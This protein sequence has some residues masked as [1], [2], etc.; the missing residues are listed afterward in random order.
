VAV[1]LKE[2]AVRV[3]ATVRGDDSVLIEGIATLRNAG[4]RDLS[5]FAN[6]RYRRD[7]RETRAGAVLLAPEDL[8]DCPVP[9]LVAANTRLA[10]A[11]IAELLH[12]LPAVEAGVHPDASVSP[13]AELGAGVVV[14]AGSVVEAGARLGAG[15]QVGPGC[16]V[17]RDVR[18]GGGSRL[19]ASVTLCHG[20]SIGCRVLIHP[21][22]VIGADGFG[23]ALEEGVWHKVPQIGSVQI[24]D[25]VEIG[26]NTTVDRGAIEDTVIEEGVKLD[27]Q[28]QVAHNVHIGAHT[29][30][31]GC[32]GIAGSTRIGRRCQIAGA[33]EISGHLE[34]VDDV[35]VTVGSLVT[36]DIREPGVYSSGSPLM[37]NG[38][39]R[40]SMARIKQIDELAKRI[41]A[42]E[43][44][45]AELGE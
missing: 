13:E 42:L 12:P 20:V 41:K 5:F 40:R 1:T 28:I 9:A 15:V 22:A 34:I 29:A 24:G 17:G 35:V 26:A 30:I 14:G 19:V 39:W 33:A 4:P 6:R 27:N 37:P 2:L 3:G 10:Y 38:Q 21:G 43:Q 32:A 44:R 23:L 31:A 25:D 11:L 8:D 16:V 7:L 45:L 18:I 36:N